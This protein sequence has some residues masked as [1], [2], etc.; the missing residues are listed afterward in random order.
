MG[1]EEKCLKL[2]KQK[3]RSR[4][5]NVKKLTEAYLLLVVK[6]KVLFIKHH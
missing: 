5:I 4:N 6:T 3:D 2:R 1:L